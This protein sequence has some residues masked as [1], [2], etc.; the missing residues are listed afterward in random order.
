MSTIVSLVTKYDIF[1]NIEL[2]FS[3]YHRCPVDEFDMTLYQREHC[4]HKYR[5]GFAEAWERVTWRQIQRSSIKLSWFAGIFSGEPR[6]MPEQNLEVV[7]CVVN[8]LMDFK[9]DLNC[10][11]W[12]VV[13]ISRLTGRWFLKRWIFH[14]WCLHL[15][16]YGVI[17]YILEGNGCQG[18]I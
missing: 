15:A 10:L 4:R 3:C 13:R 2:I 1:R 16:F 6:G 9:F 14:F 11:F 18:L 8:L 12:Y 17:I 7:L 5:Q